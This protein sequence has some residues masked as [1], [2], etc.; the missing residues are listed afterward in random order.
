MKFLKEKKRLVFLLVV[1]LL[2]LSFISCDKDSPSEPEAANKPNE[3]GITLR[4]NVKQFTNSEA[5]SITS[6]S[7]N[8]ITFSSDPGLEVGD[9]FVVPVSSKT[10]MGALRKVTSLGKVSSGNIFTVF[11]SLSELI[12]AG[13][14]SFNQPLFSMNQP[15][16]KELIPGLSISGNFVESSNLSGYL[17]FSENEITAQMSF[18]FSGSADLNLKAELTETINKE[19]TIYDHR[20]GAVT[21]WPDPPIVVTPHIHLYAKVEGYFGGVIESGLKENIDFET[22]I[23]YSNGWNITKTHNNK[24]E[25]DEIEVNFSSELKLI[26]GGSLDF[27]VYEIIGPSVGL[28]PYMRVSSNVNQNPAWKLFGGMDLTLGVKTQWISSIIPDKTWSYNIFEKE[29]SSGGASN[30]NPPNAPNN[31]NP[32]DGATG[33]ST[34]TSLSWQCSDPDGDPLTY[35]V[36]FGPSN[37][38]PLASSNQTATI[39][40]PGTL[41]ESTQYFWKIVAEDDKN[42]MTE[43]NIWNFTTGSS[44]NEI[45]RESF[46]NSLDTW[47][48]DANATDPNSGIVSSTATDGTNSLQLYGTIDG[49]WGALVYHPFQAGKSFQLEIDVK[50]S[51]EQLSGCHPDR[52]DIGFRIGDHW[53]NPAQ[54]LI[55]FR[56]N[57]E[58]VDFEGNVLL[59]Y[60][61]NQWYKLKFKIDLLDEK[62]L[63]ISYYINGNL[64]STKECASNIII[65]DSNLQLAV[66]EGTAWFDNIILTTQM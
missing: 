8:T 31:P 26:I 64:I 15:L 25:F 20:L 14:V 24:F 65:E 7:E 39:Y 45:W 30:N 42:E 3:V 46:E 44:V 28:G 17:D 37:N 55:S 32:F 35:N 21:I 43:G 29:I 27:Y 49:C 5:A 4:P 10:P 19:Y 51:S 33:V 34:T 47:M 61:T 66:Q 53:S 41:N 36:F 40:N 63:N 58:I 52:A 62:T 9:V 38:P 1:T 57:N 54:G 11:A 12:K 6:V 59:N 16:T 56:G 13:K 22:A 48:L 23:S 2:F 18:K 60:Q 50:N